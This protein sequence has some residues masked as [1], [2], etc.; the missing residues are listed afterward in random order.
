M[1]G[2]TNQP[3]IVKKIK[4]GGGG[5]HGGAWKVA[6]ADFVT[7]MMAFFLLL[8]LLSSTTEEQKKGI[9]DYFAHASI[10]R[11]MTGGGGVFGGESMT[12]EDQKVG[13]A[14]VVVQLP[15]SDQKPESPDTTDQD[16]TDANRAPSE[17]EMEKKLAEREE[18]QFKQAEDELRQAIKSIPELQRL[19][20]NLVI[21][22]T[23]EGLR[24][25]IVDQDG[26]SMFP[27]GSAEMPAYTRN[28]MG[29]IAKVV[30]KL[31]NKVAVS[32]HTDAKPYAS[33]KGYTN[34][35]LSADRANSSRRALMDAG[36]T[37]DRI[38]RVVGKAQTD[39][40]IAADPLNPRNRRISV[41]LLRDHQAPEIVEGP[42]AP[43]PTP[44]PQKRADVPKPL[45]VN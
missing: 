15:L 20:E 19:A 26:Q 22:R 6:Y 43:T 38:A 12:S 7:A 28:L 31:P 9:A 24:I 27:L 25:Q 40:L 17:E 33:S 8:W 23:E 16:S 10:A 44:P 1:A 11:V 45:K 5:H 30:Q 42:P 13:Q 29:Q 35:E 41:V 18:Q 34:W 4:K 32:G 37:S 21:D 2:K 3:I 39:P 14:S 36:L